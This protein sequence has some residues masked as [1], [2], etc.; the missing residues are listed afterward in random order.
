MKNNKSNFIGAKAELEKI[1]KM[2][3]D[4]QHKIQEAMW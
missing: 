1:W 4:S 2:S 3:A